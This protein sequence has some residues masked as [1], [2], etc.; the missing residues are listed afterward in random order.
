M[1]KTLDNSLEL[2]KYFTKQHPAWGVRELA[3]EIN[4]SH[5]IV[6]RILSTFENHG[7]MIQDPVTKKYELGIRFLEYGHIVQEKMHLPDLIYPIMKR[8]SEKTEES[9]FLTWIDGF[10][11]V[12]TVIAESTQRIKFAVSLGTRTPLYVGASCKAILAYLPKETQKK[13][14][15]TGLRAFTKNTI[16]NAEELLADLDEIREKGWSYTVGEYSDS[17]F[18]LGVP[19]FNHEQ[20]II[21]SL[22]IAGP[23]YR[24]PQERIPKVLRMLQEEAKSIQNC[25]YQYNL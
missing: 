10:E 2:L 23:E 18:G 24:M 19:L 20:E 4:M 14:I 6:Y 7:F 9:V 17:V 13:I 11:G 25:F 12:T 8:L 16:L 22:T 1:L 15:D 21:A 5:S 3:K